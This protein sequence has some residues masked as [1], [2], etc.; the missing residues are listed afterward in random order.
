[1]VREIKVTKPINLLLPTQDLEYFLGLEK[2]QLI[3]TC[4][5]YLTRLDAKLA[6][7]H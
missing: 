6:L 3:Q 4:D 1:M 5:L 2:Q 7:D